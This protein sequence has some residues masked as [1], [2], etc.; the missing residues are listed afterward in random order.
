MGTINL[1]ALIAMVIFFFK[2]YI[3]IAINYIFNFLKH[4]FEKILN[5]NSNTVICPFKNTH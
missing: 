1:L 5:G 3:Y 2:F 4:N